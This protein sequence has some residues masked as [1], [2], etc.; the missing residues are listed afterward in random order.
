MSAERPQRLKVCT[1]VG[2][3]LGSEVNE[4]QE[5]RRAMTVHCVCELAQLWPQ[6]AGLVEVVPER[7]AAFVD[8]HGLQDDQPRPARCP[9][10]LVGHIAS[11]RLPRAIEVK[12]GAVGSGDDPISDFEWADPERAQEQWIV[13]HRA[14]SSRNF[15]KVALPG[16]RG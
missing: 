10:L 8:M 15:S 3:E 5:D 1:S 12:K 7:L 2:A 6:V 16:L 9:P 11:S 4:L 13:D 14:G